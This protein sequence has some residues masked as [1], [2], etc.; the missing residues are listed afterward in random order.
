MERSS[1]HYYRVPAQDVEHGPPV[2]RRPSQFTTTQLLLVAGGCLCLGLVAGHLGTSP[3]IGPSE[4]A[5]GTSLAALLPDCGFPAEFCMEPPAKQTIRR[6]T[7]SS[8][9][10]TE[11]SRGQNSR[12]S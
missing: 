12:Q 4:V 9:R 6:W 3:Q 5:R 1:A 2:G 11:C 10:G 8:W 7:A